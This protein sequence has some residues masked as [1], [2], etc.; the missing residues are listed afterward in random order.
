MRATMNDY[1]LFHCSIL[2]QIDQQGAQKK[3]EYEKMV[4]DSKAK[5]ATIN[6]E[7]AKWEAMMP[8]EEMNREEALTY[9]ADHPLIRKAVPNPNNPRFY[10]HDQD[11]ADWEA[12]TK[13]KLAERGD[14][15]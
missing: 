6:T 1:N 14:H 15:H 11:Y 8:V 9:L 2:F 5:I 10:P 13:I 7:L 3:S 4:A 12:E